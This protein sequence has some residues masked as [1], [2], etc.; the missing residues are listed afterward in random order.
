MPDPA[1]FLSSRHRRTSPIGSQLGLQFS[2]SL[3]ARSPLRSSSR[4]R[5]GRS[6]KCFAWFSLMFLR[7]AITMLSAMKCRKK[8]ATFA[9]GP[10]FT[11]IEITGS[12]SNTDTSRLFVV[13]KK[14]RGV[15]MDCTICKNLKRA[16]V[17]SLH[18]CIEARSSA[19]YGVCTKLAALKRVDMERAR[20]DLQEH[21]HV[22]DS[23]VSVFALLPGRELPPTLR[24]RAA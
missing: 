11:S 1:S 6:G 15:G 17:A 13:R 10:H 4:H 12:F 21:R 2:S 3:Q 24:R 16:F 7:I 5:R 20:Y 19:C 8:R 22:C 9:P 18:E 23:A 14:E